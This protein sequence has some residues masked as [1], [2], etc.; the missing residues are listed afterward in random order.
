MRMCYNKKIN[1][2]NIPIKNKSLLKT[3]LS[4]KH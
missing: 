1:M 4:K 3:K 2:R